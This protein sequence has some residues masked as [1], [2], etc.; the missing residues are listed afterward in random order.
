MCYF[1]KDVI[2]LWFL[3][4]AVYSAAGEGRWLVLLLPVFSELTTCAK[5][6]NGAT[7]TSFVPLDN[8]YINNRVTSLEQLSLAEFSREYVSKAKCLKNG[9]KNVL[10]TVWSQ[11]LM[12][13]TD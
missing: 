12:P 8:K 1:R 9:K 5:E 10:G 7:V 11:F 6:F 13:I 3:R 4:V 2:P